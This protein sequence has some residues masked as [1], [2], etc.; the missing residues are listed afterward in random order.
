MN[1]KQIAQEL[2]AGC[3]V[4]SKR[5]NK[6]IAAAIIAGKSFDE[7]DA[8]T[9]INDWPETYVWLKNEMAINSAAALMGSAKSDKKTAS[10]R[11]NGARGGRPKGQKGEK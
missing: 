3:P 9:K 6:Q 1:R 5:D 2:M 7:I 11:K 4:E 10:S 8:T